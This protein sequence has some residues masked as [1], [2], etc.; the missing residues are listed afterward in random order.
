MSPP[1][2]TD[3]E[4]VHR[5]EAAM[6]PDA[7]TD[8]ILSVPVRRSRCADAADERVRSAASAASVRERI[9]RALELAAQAK[10]FALRSPTSK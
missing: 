3:G 4:R 6:K 9:I 2:C 1:N 8:L 7:L 5:L 10:S